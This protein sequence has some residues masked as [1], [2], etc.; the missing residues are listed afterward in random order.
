MLII[1]IIVVCIR[2]QICNF[3]RLV[4]H[5]FDMYIMPLQSIV[6]LLS[7]CSLY[8]YVPSKMKFFSVP[9]K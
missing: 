5:I 1:I 2:I 4:V 3:K 8:M 9:G 7:Q 6:V